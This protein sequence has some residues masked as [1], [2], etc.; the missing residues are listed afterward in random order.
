[1]FYYK[2]VIRFCGTNYFGW[3]KQTQLPSIQ[4]TVAEAFSKVFH[5]PELKVIGSGRTDTGVHAHYYVIKI[6]TRFQETFT[7]PLLALNSQL[8]KDVE[9]IEFDQCDENF[10]PTNDAKEKTYVYLFSNKKR[11]DPLVGHI[12]A[13]YS[14]NLNFEVMKQAA[15]L[16]IG[17][18]DFS[19][20]YT[21]GSDPQNTVRRIFDCSLSYVPF[22]ENFFIIPEHYQIKV[23]GN[24]FLKQM[25]RLIVATIWKAGEGKITL[26]QIQ[27][28][29]YQ[30]T[31][32][33]L[34]PVAPAN[35]LHKFKVNY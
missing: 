15:S 32:K 2:A 11:V 12:V 18:Y 30:P 22:N 28:E 1:M 20:F 26:D 19:S 6:I 34:A 14:Y 9:V 24:G 3:Q 7:R 31:G 5:D 21:Q 10:R 29:L 16:F 35:G 4:E 27:Q 8:P 33:H 25:V 17:E 23:T 13:N